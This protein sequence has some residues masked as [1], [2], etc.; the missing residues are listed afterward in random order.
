MFHL[1]QVSHPEV[2][3]LIKQQVTGSMRR[4]MS[5]RS[6]TSQLLVPSFKHIMLQSSKDCNVP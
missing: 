6:K 4:V 3:A 2:N 1:S 5:L